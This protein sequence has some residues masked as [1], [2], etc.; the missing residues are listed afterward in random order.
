LPC[1]VLCVKFSKRR[2]DKSWK[3]GEACS[4]TPEARLRQPGLLPLARNSM[5]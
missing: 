4:Q 2:S 3:K 1:G 5:F